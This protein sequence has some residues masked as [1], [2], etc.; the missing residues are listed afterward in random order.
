MYL[1]WIWMELCLIEDTH[2][3]CLG[4]RQSLRVRIVFYSGTISLISSQITRT[5][6]KETDAGVALTAHSLPV[7]LFWTFKSNKQNLS[8]L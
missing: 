5:Q 6:V 3:R 1:P 2:Y 8:A 7:G 4:A